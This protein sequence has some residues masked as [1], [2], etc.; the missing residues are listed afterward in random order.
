RADTRGGVREGRAKAVSARVA[1]QCRV[2][3]KADR[4][5]ETARR[6]GDA[7]DDRVPTA[8]LVQATQREGADARPEPAAPELLAHTDR[9][10]LPDAV[11]VVRPDE[12][13]GREP[14]VGS[15]DDAIEGRA[16]RPGGA[17]VLEARLGDARRRPDVP[18]DRDT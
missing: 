8:L 6:V 11:L 5:V 4:L 15:L 7:V 17:H 3:A 12:A 10:E 1:H 18:V 2:A 9:L 14:S 13:I 16:V